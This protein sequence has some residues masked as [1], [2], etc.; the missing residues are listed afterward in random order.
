[1]LKLPGKLRVEGIVLSVYIAEK[2]STRKGGCALIVSNNKKP[3]P[4]LCGTKNLHSTVG[5]FRESIMSTVVHLL[6][7]VKL[8]YLISWLVP[9]YY[10]NPAI[11]HCQETAITAHLQPPLSSTMMTGAECAYPLPFSPITINK[12]PTPSLLPARIAPVPYSAGSILLKPNITSTLF[13]LYL[14]RM[15]NHALEEATTSY[16][17]PRRIKRELIS[18]TPCIRPGEGIRSSA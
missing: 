15:H 11:P 12:H 4:A 3:Q 18:P 16:P 9:A 2:F 1:M 14:Q 6:V 10:G 8:H 7:P 13:L 5:D 17:P